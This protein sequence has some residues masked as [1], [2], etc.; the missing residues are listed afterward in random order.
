MQAGARERL[1]AC[2]KGKG[3]PMASNHDSWIEKQHGFSYSSDG[4]DLVA[5]RHQTW[6]VRD[7]R[8]RQMPAG[9]TTDHALEKMSDAVT[10]HQ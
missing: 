4:G 1:E 2:A 8:P 3:D 10:G 5:L 7:F 9:F 6:A